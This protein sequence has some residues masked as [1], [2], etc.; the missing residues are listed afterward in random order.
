MA[1]VNEVRLA[2]TRT[3]TL[4]DVSTSIEASVTITR[5]TP[6]DTP[7]DMEEM[8]IQ[9]VRI[10]MESAVTDIISEKQ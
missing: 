10:F 9:E 1:N 8:A 3:V 7:E 2:L 5:D 6:S 4:N